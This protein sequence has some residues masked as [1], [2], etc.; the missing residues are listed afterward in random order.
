MN[1]NL[2]QRRE[3]MTTT[4]RLILSALAGL[5]F[6][7]IIAA[8][9]L[10]NQGYSEGLQWLSNFFAAL[11]TLLTRALLLSAMASYGFFF[12]YWTCLGGVLG[13]LGNS[14]WRHRK[15]ILA[16]LGSALA[17]LHVIALLQLDSDIRN[18]IKEIF[19]GI[20]P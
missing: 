5:V 17:I 18:S 19:R 11:S 4:R 13:W 12:I 9:G 6:G 3:V 16:A 20:L 1:S 14:T 15:R 10:L 2:A 8:L 7:A